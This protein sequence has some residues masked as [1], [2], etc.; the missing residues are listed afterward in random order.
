MNS[1]YSRHEAAWERARKEFHLFLERVDRRRN[2]LGCFYKNAWFR[3]VPDISYTLT[4]SLFRP[5]SS[6]SPSFSTDETL[7]IDRLRK[8]ID[9]LTAR[10][11]NIAKHSEGQDSANWSAVQAL[12]AQADELRKLKGKLADSR[13]DESGS[14]ISDLDSRINDI[15]RQIGNLRHD[16]SYQDSTVRQELS[17][18]K[19]QIG[20]KKKELDQIRDQKERKQQELLQKFRAGFLNRKSLREDESDLFIKFSHRAPRVPERSSWEMLAEMQHYGV[21]TRLLDWT[22]SLAVALYFALEDYAT[23]LETEWR[24]SKGNERKWFYPNGIARTPCIWIL[25]PFLLSLLATEGNRSSIWDFTFDRG[26]DYYNSFLRSPEHAGATPWAFKTPIPIYPPWH[27]NRIH[28]QQGVFTVHGID[29]APIEEQQNTHRGLLRNLAK[30]KDGS[31]N[32]VGRIDLVPEAAI[33]G[34]RWLKRYL[35]LSRF[36][37]YRD[38]DS[39]GREIATSSHSLKEWRSMNFGR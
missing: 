17:I 1:E 20:Q 28:A 11:A 36:S 2:E 13:N 14:R 18:I 38:P 37:V 22:E 31:H 24:S 15:G 39:L 10:R 29:T 6:L 25:N 9:D 5:P 32:F 35:S 33:Y 21:P 3:G 16:E 27:N 23:A 34:V 30:T 7:K 12:K 19:T 8:E 4:P 26:F